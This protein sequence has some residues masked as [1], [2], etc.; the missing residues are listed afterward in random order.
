MSV[1]YK[2][3]TMP[4]FRTVDDISCSH[5]LCLLPVFLKDT[6]DFELSTVKSFVSPTL[7]SD[8]G[9]YKHSSHLLLMLE[10]F[11]TS[12]GPLILLVDNVR[13]FSILL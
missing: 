3:E 4:P 1:V 12:L 6:A 2:L 8:G 10:F 13:S 5:L 9:G 11:L 7:N